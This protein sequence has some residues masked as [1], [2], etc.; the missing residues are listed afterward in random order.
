[1]RRRKLFRGAPPLLAFALGP[2]QHAAPVRP[3]YDRVTRRDRARRNLH[4]HPNCLEPRIDLRRLDGADTRGREAPRT[5][6]VDQAGRDEHV[7][8][9]RALLGGHHVAVTNR[10]Q[11]EERRGVHHEEQSSTA[12]AVRKRKDHSPFTSASASANRFAFDKF[13]LQPHDEGNSSARRWLRTC[14]SDRPDTADR[15]GPC[16]VRARRDPRPLHAPAMARTS[17]CVR[18][19]CSPLLSR[20]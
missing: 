13:G 17:A 10:G 1:M 18:I 3:H 12:K 19:W 6:S 15:P 4:Q 11:R 14:H 5:R 16:P 7:Q 20:R 2:N 8:A 9:R